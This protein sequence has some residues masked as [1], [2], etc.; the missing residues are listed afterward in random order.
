MSS[1]IRAKWT[2]R[3]QIMWV[4]CLILMFI[5]LIHP[6]GL[7]TPV[8]KQVK[9]YYNTIKNL[10]EGSIVA[11]SFGASATLLDEQEAQFLAT[12][13]ILFETKQ[14]VIF[15]STTEDGPMVLN[16]NL[17][18][19][20]PESYGYVYGEDY[21]RL[22]YAFLGEAGQAA[23]S[24]NIRSV[25]T[26]DFYGTNLNNIPLMKD[27]NSFEDI[28]LLIYEYTSCTDIEWAVRQWVV[29]HNTPTIATTLG[30]CGPMAAPYYPTQV[31]GFLSG[32]VA[33]TELEIISG[34]PGPGA[35]ISDA[36]NLGIIPFFI[37]ILHT[38][39]EYFMQRRKE[40]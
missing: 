36:S 9:D 24:E 22:G 16:M 13:K 28:D 2:K 11:V 27:I 20:K 31:Q 15:F 21:V 7:P 29:A 37:A 23:F 30:C 32:S 35:A 5:P 40:K 38:N 4:A 3:Y 33:G 18:K 34:N 17:N 10:P 39:V 8:S 1:Q 26:S 25:Y 6:L 19:V 12:W 14:K